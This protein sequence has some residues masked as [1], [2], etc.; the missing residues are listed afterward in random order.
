MTESIKGETT[1]Q[2]NQK[3]QSERFQLTNQNMI[4]GGLIGV[5]ISAF[6]SWNGGKYSRVS[7]AFK[8]WK[9][10]RNFILINPKPLMKL[11]TNYYTP[12]LDTVVNNFIC[13]SGEPGIGKSYHFQ[14]MSYQ[15]SGVRPALYL[16]FKASG[17]DVTFEEDIA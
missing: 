7:A 6:M 16:S 15:Q 17:R 12:V 14:N 13:F 4:R 10:T 3:N 8:R 2:S 1:Q 9:F 11:S 5:A